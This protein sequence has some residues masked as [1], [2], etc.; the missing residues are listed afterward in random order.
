MD[1]TVLIIGAGTFGTSTACH[2]AQ[3]YH[4]ASRITVI[5][6]FLSPPK[7]AASVDINR[8]I[9]TDYPDSMY[10]DL[11][12]EAIHPWFWSIEL[13]Q[14][15]HKTG[16]VMID[17]KGSDLA[18]RI[19][20]VYQERGSTQTSEI[21]AEELDKRWAFL[22]GTDTSG[23]GDV[24]WNPEAGWCDAANA[25]ASFMVAAERR[26]VKRITAKVAELLLDAKCGRIE[27]VR[28]TDGR[29]FT[30]DKVV[31]AVGAWTSN[32]LSPVED[33]LEIPER[34]RVE[35]QVKATGTVSAYYK[36]SD[37]EFE[38]LANANMPIIVYGSQGEVIPPSTRDGSKYL[39]YNNS[40]TTFI[41][42]VTTESGHKISVP[43]DRSQN[44]VPNGIKRETERNLTTKLLPDF[45]FGKQAEYWRICWDA[46]TPSEDLLLC[47]HPHAKLSNLYLAT[48]GSFHGYKCVSSIHIW[49]K[50]LSLPS[51]DFY[52]SWGSI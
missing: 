2:L 9:R 33:Q 39:K 43:A 6:E 25:T 41:N 16:W 44:D 22:E 23:F 37:E 30:A 47:K 32:M 48:G 38:R 10:C 31:L 1:A 24:Y 3:R 46:V 40:Q 4:D 13:G 8:V 12:I 21:S 28:T 15:F 27:G 29:R 42:T 14:H 50:L 45:T 51:P 49:C 19:R 17:E 36:L 52:R 20:H 34:H 18:K 7:P 35:H 11:A 26:G 5:D